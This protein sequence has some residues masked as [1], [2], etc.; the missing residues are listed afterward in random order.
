MNP[1][2]WLQTDRTV[3]FGETDAA[4]VMH[5]H[6]LLRWC[7]EAYEESLQTF[8]ASVEELFP[9]P[10]HTPAVALPLIHC[11]ADYRL[12]LICGDHL[13]ILLLPQQLDPCT[14]EVRYDFRRDD[15]TVARGLTR[16]RSID[17]VSRDRCDLPAVMVRWLARSGSAQ[18]PPEG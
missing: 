17:A 2:H 12:P 10:G 6:H 14:F 13:S 18:Q 8:G 5:F 4:G 1:C 15:R 11:S 16:H 7:H 3:R 9:L